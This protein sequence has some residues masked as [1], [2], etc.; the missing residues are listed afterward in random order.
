MKPLVLVLAALVVTTAL[1]GCSAGAPSGSTPAPGGNPGTTGTPA[2]S[3][4]PAATA[5]SKKVDVCTALPA[6]SVSAITGR[7]YL[8]SAPTSDATTNAC[9]YFGDGGADSSLNLGV[10]LYYGGGSAMFAQQVAGISTG[11]TTNISGFGSKAIY[12]NGTV[13]ALFGQDVIVA[14]DYHPQDVSVLSASVL[15]KVISTLQSARQ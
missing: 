5:P 2:P 8:T 15:E 6:T 13:I 9:Q 11:T 14:S 12:K 1:A 4:A 10:G 3:A 7:E